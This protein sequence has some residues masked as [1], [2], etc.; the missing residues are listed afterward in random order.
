MIGAYWLQHFKEKKR[1]GFE[2]VG[3]E[4]GRS[5]EKERK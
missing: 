2:E 5:G 1:V 4:K 3:E